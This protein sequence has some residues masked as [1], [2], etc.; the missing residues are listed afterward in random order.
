MRM[1]V[2]PPY[3]PGTL[4][5]SLGYYEVPLHAGIAA[6]A[7]DHHWELDTSVVSRSHIPLPDAR[8]N[9]SAVL[10]T[11]DRPEVVEWLRGLD[12]PAVRM[13]E[14]GSP[15]LA[16][17]VS[18][19]PKVECDYDSI[20]E[21]GARHLLTLGKV[22]FGFYCHTGGD[23]SRAIESAFIR[24]MRA[25]GAEPFV[26]DF[27]AE[28]P[29]F[30]IGVL[31]PRD[32][33]LDWIAA[34]LSALPLPAAIMTEDDRFALVLTQAAHR[35]GLRVPTDIAIL[36]AD[37]NRLLLGSSPIGIS[38]VDSN[39]WMVG[40]QAAD[41][42][43]RLVSGE[44]PPAA[45]IRIPARPVVVRESTTT[46]HGQ[47][48]K[49]AAALRYIRAHFRSPLSVESVANHVGLSARGLQKIMLKEA[50][51]SIH[52]EIL[53]LRLDAAEQL[54][55]E[56]HLKLEAI[57]AETGLGNA[58]NLCRVFLK[59]RGTTPRQSQRSR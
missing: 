35:L 5:L 24:T 21:A 27:R 17:S 49:A 2:D 10:A 37:D 25:A 33:W 40:Y 57:A 4:M 9:W 36:G 6:W 20:G 44:P 12:C 23:D 29:E 30:R 43:A 14:A 54:L 3:K 13:L 52:Q 45:P 47:H 58:K 56:T 55:T 22:N 48:P 16:E 1:Q 38:S 51:P 18:G 7:K 50:C 39:L 31:S 8:R 34:K 15:E 32:L 26:I 19:I 11:I 53:R 28:H 59:H 46:F 41:L 42:A